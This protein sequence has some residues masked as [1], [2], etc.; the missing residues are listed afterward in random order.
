MNHAV[1]R[2]EPDAPVVYFTDFGGAIASTVTLASNNPIYPD[3]A[4]TQLGRLYPASFPGVS[5]FVTDVIRV[6]LLS[7]AACGTA[8]SVTFVVKVPKT[9]PTG[10][11]LYVLGFDAATGGNVIPF[12]AAKELD[13]ETFEVTATIGT[14]TDFVAYADTDECAEGLA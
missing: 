14:P 11:G 1:Y 5:T 8:G 3:N 4:E 13:P 6:E 7:S 9:V 2:D 10:A 12:M